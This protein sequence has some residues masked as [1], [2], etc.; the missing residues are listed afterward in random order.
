MNRGAPAPNPNATTAAPATPANTSGGSSAPVKNLADP[1]A[2]APELWKVKPDPPEHAVPAITG[3]IALRV[4]PS[5][6]GGDVT[7]PSAPSSFVAVGRNGDQKD[8]R[9]VWDLATKKQVGAIRGTIKLDKPYAL[10]ADGTLFA[11]KNDR[12]FTVYETKTGRMVAQLAVSSPFADFVDFTGAGQVI[13]GTAGDRRFEIW[14]LKAQKSELDVSPRDRVAKESVVLSPGRRYLAMIGASTLWIYDLQSGRKAGE[15]PVPK[16]GA[17][18]LSCKDL[19]FSPDG[20]ELAGIFDSFGQHLLCWDVATGRLTHQFRY[21]DKSGVKAPPFYEGPAID[22]LADRAGWLVF[23]ALVIDHQSGQKTYTIPS[24]TPGADK[25]P[26]KIVGKNLVLITVGDGQNRVVRGFPLPTDTIATAAKL[27]QQGGSAADA[28]LPPLKKADMTSAR[29]VT[30]SGSAPAWS[31]QPDA[32]RASSALLRR[33]IPTQVPASE[34]VGLLLTGTDG[35]QAALV[36]IPGANVFDPSQNEGKPR[37]LLRFDSLSG[38]TLSRIEISGLCDPLALSPDGARVLTVDSRDRRR[39]DVY[40]TAEGTPVAGWRPYEKEVSDDEK[41]IVWADFATPDQVVTVNRSGLLV[42]WSLPHCKAVYMAEGACEGSPALSPGRKY[43]ATYLGGTFRFLDAATGE[44]K[45]EARAPASA[46]SSRGELKGAAFQA[47]GSALVA[48]IGGQQ[49]IRWSLDSGKVTADFPV[50]MSINP[51]PNSHHDAI[52][53]CGPSHVLLDGRV[54][55]DLDKRSHIWSYYGPT[56]SSGGPDGRHWYVAGAFNQPAAV[57]PLALPEEN[58]SRVVAMVS[59]PSAKPSLRVG[60]QATVQLEL[61]GPPKNNDAFKKAITDGLNAKLRAN[62]MTPGNGGPVWFIVHV[63]EKDTGKKVSYGELGDSPFSSPRGSIAITNLV[64]EVQFADNQGRI[65]LAPKQT[66]GLL[67]GFRRIYRL[68]PG[69]TLESYL[70]N[71]QW[72]GVKMFV[73]GIGLPYF[74]ARQADGVV[75][76]PG[77]TDLNTVR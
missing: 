18:D 73:N 31:V 76:L 48:L 66:L 7:Y 54:L 56:V 58:V 3:D 42:L 21:D 25:G 65:P 64:C 71:N 44:L 45:G 57:T 70:K 26:R 12:N 43:L 29:K 69:E 50:P 1:N 22:F 77:T 20:T 72:G 41:A 16:N 39:L 28:A 23:G 37:R 15:A 14:D 36:S 27:I 6:F 61:N 67:Q 38:R 34:A 2:P 63:E 9:Q 17:F 55:V 59:D 8:V 62:G 75:M 30:V 53:C 10:S 46:S 24:D 51:G 60:M 52:E 33:S 49:I 68:P 40:S 32:P 13:T 35:H 19:A 74:V 5:F 11:G 47:D 4:P